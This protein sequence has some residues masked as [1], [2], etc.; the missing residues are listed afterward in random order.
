MKKVAVEEAVGMVL[1]HDMTQIIPGKYKGARFK[2]GDIIKEGDIPLLKD[3]G[4][5]HIYI[6]EL[7]EGM[8]HENEAA[9]RI[10]HA[11]AGEG[12]RLTKPSEGKVSYIA[13]YPG[14]LEIDLDRLY[15]INNIDDI[16]LSTLHTDIVV[17]EGQVVA[18]TRINPLVTEVRNI[19][20]VEDLAEDEEVLRILPFKQMKIGVIITGNEVYHGR[21]EDKFGPILESKLKKFGAELLEVIYL[22][23]DA[24]EITT[25]IMGL[26]AAG[27]DAVITGGGMSVDPDDVTP[28][29]IRK[30]GAEVI[31]Y[32]AP[33]LPGSQFMMAYL[34]DMPIM[35]TPACAMFHETTIFDLIFPKIMVGKKVT[36]ED[37]VRLGHGGFCMKCEKCR[38]PI[39]PFGK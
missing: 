20:Q 3:M 17:Q 10:G 8:I 27:A 23:D 18:G 2:K 38:Y 29:G 5:D 31:K 36:R 11:T 7:K 25:T 26:K 13:Q 4:K 24:T 1:G 14:L 16:I 15:K 28:T 9:E 33:V 37:I 34:D 12:L 22:P 39:C 30:S 35:G 21:I 32:G 19:K 6:L